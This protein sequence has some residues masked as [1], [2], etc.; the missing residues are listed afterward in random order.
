MTDG[1]I[2]L[3]EDYNLSPVIICVDDERIILTG[4]KEQLRN[5]LDGVQIETAESGEEGLEVFQEF[6]DAGESV[7]IVISDQLMPG[8]RG[9]AFLEAVHSLSPETLNILLTGQA[10]ADSVGA[11][12][13]KARLYRYISKPWIEDDLVMT[14]REALKAWR[15]A[16][17]LR[18]KERELLLAHSASLRFVPR[19]FLSLLE[20]NRLEDV[21]CGDY[22]AREMHVSFTDV[23]G[24][25]KLAEGKEPGEMFEFLNEYVGLI[26]ETV[27]THG[28][29]ISSLEGDGVLSL[30]P[31]SADDALRAGIEMH[32]IMREAEDR[33][34]SNT[35]NG[36]I[37]GAA[38][39]SGFL[40]LGAIGNDERLKCDVVGDAVNLCSRIEGLT[41]QF[42]V[43]MLISSMTREHLSDNFA[44][45]DVGEVTVKGRSSP[46]RLYEVLDAATEEDRQLK[47]ES[48]DSFSRALSLFGSGDFDEAYN[49]F[50]QILCAN[51]V[52]G[53]AKLYLNR[54]R[55]L[56][57]LDGIP[58]GFGVLDFLVK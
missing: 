42:D 14:I 15:Q 36:P 34:P 47:Q 5:N 46:V 49:S 16:R 55:Q 32:R 54:C 22:I 53:A 23:R 26:E 56:Q 20:K 38:V 45:R 33:L 51:P 50:E 6:L 57:N 2:E 17:T 41:R 21:Q 25:T 43:S 39:N 13:N 31:D 19:E 37:I 12:V 58:D 10:T 52:D 7:P 28:G 3:P 8:M 1:D 18:I 9:E 29:F 48:L 44:L 30:F 27:R 35:E 24:F 40:L 4:L 11:A